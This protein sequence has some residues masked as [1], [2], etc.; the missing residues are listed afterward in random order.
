MR[1]Y[2]KPPFSLKQY[3]IAY[4]N[5]TDRRECLWMK[6]KSKDCN[7]HDMCIGQLGFNI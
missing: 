3:C 6:L 4:L 1:I 7:A 5:W 2:L